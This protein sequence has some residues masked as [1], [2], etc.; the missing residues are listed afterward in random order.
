MKQ[1]N[2]KWRKETSG[3]ESLIKKHMERTQNKQA[4]K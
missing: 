2:G 1:Q 4:V 3:S